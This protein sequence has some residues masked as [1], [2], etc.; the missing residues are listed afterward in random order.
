MKIERKP[1]T[2]LLPTPVV[3][4]SVAGH[5]KEKANIITLA[6]VG[7][8]CSSPPMLSVAIRPSRHSHGLVNAAREFV[9]NIPRAGQVAAVDLAGVW[10]GAE[11]DKFKEL[12]FTARPATLV[13]APLIEECPINIECVVRHQ[14]ALGAHDVYLAEIV[15]THYDEALLDSHG[16]LKTA[17]LD[18]MAY[19]DGEYWS[20]GERLGSYGQAAK[21]LKTEKK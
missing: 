19:V 6:W 14:L 11:H 4:L 8:V 16:R 21:A 17:E 15:A 13:A 18:A 20:L 2:A 7:T 12:G 9:V 10:S 1:S 5:G 3:L